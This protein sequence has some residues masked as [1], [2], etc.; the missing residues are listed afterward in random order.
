VAEASQAL[1]QASAI[2]QASGNLHVALT[3]G[4]NLAQLHLEQG[5]LQQA[6]TLCQQALQFADEQIKAAEAVLPPAAGGVYVSLG[7]LFYEQNDLAAAASH[8]E[9]G[10]KLGERG[11]DLAI[12]VMGYLT[13]ARLQLAAADPQGAFER[14]QQ[15]EQM[16]RRY[17]SSYWAAQ[18][19]ATQARLWISQGQLD[20]AQR[21]AQESKLHGDDEL[22]YLNEVEYIT[23]ARLLVA[24]NRLVEAATL[25]ARLLQAA[26]TGGCLGRVIEILMLQALVYQAQAEWDQAIITLERA[27]M[28]AEPEGYV[29]LFLDEGAPMEK[30]LQRMKAEGGRMKRYIDKLLSGYEK[31]K[32]KS[33]LHP[34]SSPGAPRSAVLH[35]L[36]EP[37]SERELELLRLIAAGL[38]NSQMAE[39]LVV[40]VGTIKWH[41]N[42]IY[43]KLDVRSRTQAVARARE[44]QLL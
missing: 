24:Q 39:T 11:A 6:M 15:A 42:N 18:T 14:V 33:H 22:N 1:S 25:L 13:L 19:A 35:P 43:G 29:R 20:L 38:S 7:Q 40:T 4:W 44:L 32:Q 23:L 34:S 8:A 9:E 41:L 3:A 16:A 12:L 27:L 31:A 2:S 30:L 37:L 5:Q 21:W 28:L 36:I 10:I 17:N 26:E